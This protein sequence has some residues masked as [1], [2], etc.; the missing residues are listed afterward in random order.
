MRK[1][2][3]PSKMELLADQ[4]KFPE[5]DPAAVT[6]TLSL[7]EKGR[8]I[9]RKVV[10]VLKDRYD[11]SEGR[12]C[13]LLALYREPNGM[14]P[15][16]LADKGGV[17]RATITRLLQRMRH[18]GDI[19]VTISEDDERQKIV[20][21][22]QKGKDLMDEILPP[23]YQRVAQIVAKLTPEEQQQLIALLK[24]MD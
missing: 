1:T 22:T 14:H 11:L 5:L 12:F 24:K 13:V 10:K 15:S 7:W 9:E 8:D 21:L 2:L 6:I 18:M 4:K 20:R 19:S 16:E 17:T 23:H 3:V